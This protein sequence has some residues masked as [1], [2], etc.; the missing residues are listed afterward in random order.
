MDLKAQQYGLLTSGFHGQIPSVVENA[1]S[2]AFLSGGGA[3]EM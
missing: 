3:C 2:T 1:L